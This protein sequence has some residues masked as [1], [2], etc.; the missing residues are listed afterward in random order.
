MTRIIA[1][2]NQKGGVGKTTLTVNLGAALAAL[3]QRVAIVD[4]DPQGALTV[5]LGIDPHAIK[6]STYDILTGKIATFDPVYKH[7]SNG[8]LVAPA[9]AELVAT[10]YKLLKERDR[11]LRIRNAIFRSSTRPDYILLDT[12]PSLGMLTINALVAATELIIPVSTDY[13]AMRGVR[14]LL[15]SVWL[16][17]EKINPNLKLLALVPTMYREDSDPARAVVAEMR[18]VFKHKVTRTIIPLDETAAAAPAARK[19]VLEYRP[20]SAVAQAFRQLAEEVL[21]VR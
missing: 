4:L 21:N 8:L 10:E 7:R 13:L 19:S 5:S 2:A 12:P 9:N 6:P 16:I 17:R 3:G 11:L 15:E 1:V 14:A 20:Q 18:R